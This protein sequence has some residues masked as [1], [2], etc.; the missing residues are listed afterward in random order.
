[1]AMMKEEVNMLDENGKELGN[2]DGEGYFAP[3]KA[4]SCWRK[5]RY[6]IIDQCKSTGSCGNCQSSTPLYLRLDNDCVTTDVFFSLRA[7]Y[8]KSRLP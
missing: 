6:R 8:R 1:M 7:R 5:P 3:S 4:Q 2:M